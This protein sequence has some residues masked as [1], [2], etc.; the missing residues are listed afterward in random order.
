MARPRL[1][2]SRA[3]KQAWYRWRKRLAA[4]SPADRLRVEALVVHHRILD[5]A[6]AGDPVAVQILGVDAAETGLKLLAFL[7]ER[8][9][10]IATDEAWSRVS[11]G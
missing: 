10:Q 1:Y 3:H 6:A 5:A 7:G 8:A 11:I 2:E 9:L 4:L